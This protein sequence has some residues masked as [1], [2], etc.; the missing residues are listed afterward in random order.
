MLIDMPG[1]KHYIFKELCYLFEFHF[2]MVLLIF[3]NI[4]K[5]N[6]LVSLQYHMHGS[7]F[8]SIKTKKVSFHCK[9]SETKHDKF[10]P[11]WCLPGIHLWTKNK[12]QSQK[13]IHLIC[14][15]VMYGATQSYERSQED[16]SNCAF[17]G[18]FLWRQRYWYLSKVTIC[19]S[20]YIFPNILDLI[21][22]IVLLKVCILNSSLKKKKQYKELYIQYLTFKV[23]LTLSYGSNYKWMLTYTG[24][25]LKPQ[26]QLHFL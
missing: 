2:I 11:G 19:M 1:G 16:M 8:D 12:N 14:S 25:I 10:L 20:L 7:T 24:G 22:I 3:S 6:T 26:I 23:Y 21:F 15:W 5:K 4:L 9:R 13:H 17:V 18:T